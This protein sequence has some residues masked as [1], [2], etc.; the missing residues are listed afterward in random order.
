MLATAL[1]YR[2]TSPIASRPQVATLLEVQPSR[3]ESWTRPTSGLPPMVH[4][5]GGAGRLT[6]PMIGIAEAAALEGL[7]AGGLSMFRVREA[8]NHIR[9]ELGDEY[10]LASPQLFTDGT[11]A[12]IETTDGLQ[13][14]RDGQGAFREVLQRHLQPLI[15]GVDGVVEAYRIERFTSPVTIDPRFN[16]GR[17]S[18]ERNRVPLFAIAGALDAG[19]RLDDVAREYELTTDE[20]AEVDG[21]RRWLAAVA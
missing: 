12:F 18:F 6:V 9:N 7:L 8:A 1:D 16:A 20:V 14:L 19:E 10:A 15:I 11:E 21:A 4:T 17:M 3:I 2:F 5:V 13:R